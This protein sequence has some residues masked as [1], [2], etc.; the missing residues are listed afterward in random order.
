MTILG[1][2]QKQ[3]R[4]VEFYAIQFAKDMTETDNITTGYCALMYG[5]APVPEVNLSSPY[6][7]TLTDSGTLFYTGF[8]ITVPTGA[9][10]GYRIMAANT[11]QDSAIQV[12]AFSVPPRGSII[13]LMAA[14]GWT[15]ELSATAIVV[16]SE[17]DQRIRMVI[18]GGINKTTYKAQA[19]A[20][21]AE[22]RTLEDEM[23]LKIKED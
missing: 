10:I 3:P 11:D 19:T 12:G 18:A 4:E 14:A 21:T 15:V 20:V 17:D 5:S 9:P 22:G 6:S 1:R 13:V 16:S 7:A 2:Y 8:S 23:I